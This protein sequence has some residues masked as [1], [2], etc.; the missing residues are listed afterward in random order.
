MIL[1]T[2][3]K[4][5]MHLLDRFYPQIIPDKGRPGHTYIGLPAEWFGLRIIH[6]AKLLQMGNR[7]LE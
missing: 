7:K 4:Q 5:P 6:Y 2:A 1:T 3:V